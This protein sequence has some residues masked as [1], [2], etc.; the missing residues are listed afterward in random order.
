MGG[1]QPE[2]SGDERP[3]SRRTRGIIYAQR[4][5][6]YKDIYTD[7]IFSKVSHLIPTG[8]GSGIAIPSRK[9]LLSTVSR[10]RLLERWDASRSSRQELRVARP[11]QTKQEEMTVQSL[12][13]LQAPRVFLFQSLCL[14]QQL[15]I[16]GAEPATSNEASFKEDESQA[17]EPRCRLSAD[18]QYFQYMG[19]SFDHTA[20]NTSGRNDFGKL[21]SDDDGGGQNGSTPKKR[22]A[23]RKGRNSAA[24]FRPDPHEKAQDAESQDESDD[25]TVGHTQDA[26]TG[27][28]D[29]DIAEGKDN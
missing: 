29:D 10:C 27:A 25:E 15:T 14:T 26:E 8:F 17:A 23:P 2:S 4:L 28:D 5:P 18:C 13:L 3:L 6:A 16:A 11:F 21:A 1:G 19:S 24:A 12:T 20:S 22:K 9:N 7:L